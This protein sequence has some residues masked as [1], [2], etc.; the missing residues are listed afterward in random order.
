MHTASRE[1]YAAAAARL[2][3][4]AE[5]ATPGAVAATADEIGGVAQLLGREPRLR[6]ALADPARAGQERAG[7]L[8][9]TLTGKVGEPALDVLDAL[10]GG[11][12][13][14]AAELVTAAETL[15]V[16]GLLAAADAAGELAEVEDELFRFGQV[17][18]GTSRLSA[19]LGDATVDPARRIALVADLLG[20]RARPVT[21]QLV[22]LAVRGF[23]G[24][25]FESGLH[26]LVEL[27]AEKRERQVA[28]VTVAAPMDADAQG[29][30]AA[31]LA[32]QYG[33]EVSMRFEV[34]PS[35]V[36]GMSVQV[37]AD[38]YDGTIAR[39]LAETRKALTAR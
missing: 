33:R 24:R 12:W 36:G 34:D 38:L 28:Y 18:S 25:G 10:A 32:D 23:G 14:S 17:V 5:G 20:G 27:A 13:S 16:D 1:S 19:T 26:R 39:R 35:V 29:R 21:V 9:S 31:A 2:A 3:A 11:R 6:R 7:L 30:L 37:G 15:V 22:A 8:R 4:Y